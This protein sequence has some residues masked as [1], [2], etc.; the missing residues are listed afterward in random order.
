MKKILALSVLALSTTSFAA[1]NS[2]V[3][4]LQYLPDAGTLFGDTSYNYIKFTD[5]EFDGT[6]DISQRITGMIL[7]QQIGYSLM[8]NLSLTL[9][10]GY[11]DYENKTTGESTSNTRG[12]ND[13]GILGKYRLIDSENRLDLLANLTV[14]PGDAEFKSNG[15][16][17]A[18]TGGHTAAIGAEYGAKKTGHQWSVRALYT[19]LFET[20]TKD[21][22]ASPTDTFKDDA[23]SQLFFG[24]N[25]LTQL[26]EASYIKTFASVQFEQ[27]F[28]DDDNNETMGSTGYILGGE[29]QHLMSKDLYLRGGFQS[30]I[31]GNGYNSI[32]MLYTLGAGYQF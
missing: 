17:N 26:T 9:D 30:M 7:R 28:E 10:L 29:Y 6:N 2:A 14:S 23:H 4:D 1:S 19:Y 3:N 13:I 18:Y 22:T 11:T 24:A 16:D 31:G 15:D 32:V 5:S 25:L 20:T 8:N 27:E 12:L 21:K